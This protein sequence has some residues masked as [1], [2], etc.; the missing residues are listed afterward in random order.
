MEN[1]LGRG[2][3]RD[4]FRARKFA[5]KREAGSGKREAGKGNKSGIRLFGLF[6]KFVFQRK[7]EIGSSIVLRNILQ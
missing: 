4:Y 1:H 5:V 3:Y 7:R 6:L 2:K